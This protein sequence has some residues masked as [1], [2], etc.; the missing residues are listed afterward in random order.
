[1]ELRTKRKTAIAFVLSLLM[2]M[3]SVVYC[4][5][6]MTNAASSNEVAY[7]YHDYKNTN[8]KSY[9]P[10]SLELED[11]NNSISTHSYVEG[12][13]F[14]YDSDTSIV[15]I[16]GPGGTGFIVGNHI[17]AT[18][19][20]CVYSDS[21]FINFTIQI[22]DS[23]NNVVKEISPKYVHIPKA[24]VDGSQYGNDYA[25]IEVQEDL[26]T[27]GMFKLGVPLNNY[28][29]EVTVSGFSTIPNV[30]WGIRYKAKGNV[31]EVHYNS[32]W[33]FASANSGSSGGPVY[34]ESTRFGKTYKTVIGINTAEGGTNPNNGKVQNGGV[35]I[36]E[37]KLKF[38]YSNNNCKVK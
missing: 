23:S 31:T 3:L 17:I 38:Y 25:L 33:Y 15:K 32:I 10:Y 9:I 30:Q 11:I 21:K 2:V 37:H 6:S 26:S 18:A 19:A 5:P 28:R 8:L 13:D 34:V 36:D 24:Y 22:L 20:H 1:M 16:E 7:V 14:M 12:S 27:Y 35:N 4:L 29:G